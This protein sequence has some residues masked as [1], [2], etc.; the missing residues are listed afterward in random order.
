MAFT[1]KYIAVDYDGI[2]Y[3]LCNQ[4]CREWTHPYEWEHNGSM[5]CNAGCGI[6]AI[7]HAAQYL[8]GARV[9]P[10]ELADFAC[11]TGGRGDDGTD[12]PVLLSAMEEH[13]LAKKHGFSYRF[14][15]LRNDLDTLHDHLLK[16][17]AALCNLRVGHIVALIGGRTIDGEK[18][19]LAADPF[20]ESADLRVRDAVRE[21]IPGSEVLSP[22]KNDAGLI[23][24]SQETYALFWATLSTVKDFN[25]LYRLSR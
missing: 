5:L 6:F 1:G 18:Q 10:E 3:E 19:V 9:V 24:G 4:R 25:L 20:S 14:D 23:C 16:G 2:H 21:C 8:G 17:N 11:M 15:G 22:I 12:R 7:S 13:G